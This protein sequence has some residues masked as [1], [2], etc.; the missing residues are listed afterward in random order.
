MRRNRN[1]RLRDLTTTGID[2]ICKRETKYPTRAYCRAPAVSVCST[3][4]GEHQSLSCTHHKG[5]PVWG[6]PQPGA[7]PGLKFH[8]PDKRAI[9][10]FSGLGGS[11]R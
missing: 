6:P 1:I 4:G 10:C 7:W 2:V 11:Y 9:H 3:A 5:D 8:R